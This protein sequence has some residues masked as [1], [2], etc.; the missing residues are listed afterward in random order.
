M[1]YTLSFLTLWLHQAETNFENGVK[2]VMLSNICTWAMTDL[3]VT[4]VI[5]QCKYLSCDSGMKTYAYIDNVDM[6]IKYL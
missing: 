6:F 2:I 1:Y 4:Y 5:I 3:C